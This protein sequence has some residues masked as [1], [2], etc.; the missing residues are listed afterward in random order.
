ML[1]RLVRECPRW[2]S[3][4]LVFGTEETRDYEPVR[5]PMVD[6]RAAHPRPIRQ[7]GEG[8][9]LGLCASTDDNAAG[10]DAGGREPAR[11]FRTGSMS[12]PEPWRGYDHAD[13]RI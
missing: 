7:G 6:Q 12:P 3:Q 2:V 9:A 1:S 11:G 10:R 8:G 4:N 13:E 5:K